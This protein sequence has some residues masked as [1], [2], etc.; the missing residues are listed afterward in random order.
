MLFL[1]KNILKW[2]FY[3]IVYWFFYIFTWLKDYERF[4]SLWAK[5]LCHFFTVYISWNGPFC[6]GLTRLIDVNNNRNVISNEFNIQYNY[7][8]DRT[9]YCSDWTIDLLKCEIIGFLFF[10]IGKYKYL[11]YIFYQHKLTNLQYC[12]LMMK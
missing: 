12:I 5:T 9:W 7:E 6:L 1:S 8:L 2:Q 11:F 3:Y 4:R 10:Y